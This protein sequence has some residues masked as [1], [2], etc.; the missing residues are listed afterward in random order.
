M[1]FSLVVSD[2]KCP[3]SFLIN[4]TF[5]KWCVTKVAHCTSFNT[6]REAKILA[7][8]TELTVFV[9]ACH[10]NKFLILVFSAQNNRFIEIILL[11][12][13]KYYST[14]LEKFKYGRFI[15][16]PS[17]DTDYFIFHEVLSMRY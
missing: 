17:L 11:S 4:F 9:L 7:K 8:I 1:R 14:V 2:T 12:I 13:H 3:I 6:I 5:Y 15:T 16:T 10:C